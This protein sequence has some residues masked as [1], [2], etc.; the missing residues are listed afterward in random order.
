MLWLQLGP[1]VAVAA[2][3]RIGAGVRLISCIILDD[4]E[5][6][7][8]TLLCTAAAQTAPLAELTD[9]CS[10]LAK[11]VARGSQILCRGYLQP[12][13]TRNVGPT[14]TNKDKQRL[15]FPYEPHN[16]AFQ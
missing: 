13:A 1:N 16:I 4:V 8:G 9:A 15:F 7:V 5:I 14:L 11:R 2:N 10:M 12:V 3:A 6:K